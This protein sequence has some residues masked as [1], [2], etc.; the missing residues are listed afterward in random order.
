MAYYPLFIDAGH[1]DALVV[2]CGSV[3]K[4]KVHSL[5]ASGA[6]SVL[7]VDPGLCRAAID[8][9]T[10]LGPV[11]CKAEPFS[12]QDLTGKNLVY[13]ATASRE[14]NGLVSG[15]CAERGI[16]CNS[17]D[18]P[19]E[20]SFLVPAHFASGDITVAFS[21]GGQSPALA[22]VLRE[23]LEKLLGTRYAVLLQVLGA[24][25]PA[26]LQLGLSSERNA[27]IFRAIARSRLPEMLEQD[28]QDGALGLLQ[29]LVPEALHPHLRDFLYG[30]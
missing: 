24:L 1:I 2:G 3:G 18:A 17:A 25:R 29:G 16:L 13:A 12:R 6:R 15:L 8:E 28:D 20:G 14:V 30:S 4:R 19:R 10:A 5:C 27:E 21:T 22:R 26:L 9:L 7:V 11:Q 23:E